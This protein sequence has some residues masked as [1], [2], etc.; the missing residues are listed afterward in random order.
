[1]FDAEGRRLRYR[2]E[3][4]RRA[5]RWHLGLTDYSDFDVVDKDAAG[6]RARLT[7]V[8]KGAG[9]ERS[10]QDVALSDLVHQAFARWMV[11]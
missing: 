8:L 11:D 2:Y 1:M 3:P 6:L 5:K 7:A 9:G 4:R 10:A